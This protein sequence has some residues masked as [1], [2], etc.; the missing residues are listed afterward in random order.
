VPGRRPAAAEVDGPRLAAG[1]A[2]VHGQAREADIG[3]LRPGARLAVRGAVPGADWAGWLRRYEDAMTV[4]APMRGRGLDVLLELMELL[5]P[6]EAVV[7]DLGAGP[8]SLAGRLL[9][10]LPAARCVAVDTDPVMLELGRRVHGD[11][12]GRLRWVEADL[13][14][15]GWR[16][17]VGE[18]RVDAV[19]SSAVL[20]YLPPQDLVG[21]LREVAGLLGE[22]G[23]FL[24]ADRL[25]LPA[26]LETV[27]AALHRAGECRGE[28]AR[29]AVAQDWSGW[30]EALRDEPVLAAAFA[31]RER[32][33]LAKRGEGG[34][35]DGA[36]HE[37][38]LTAAG[39]REVATVWQDLE[40]R[41]LLAVR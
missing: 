10:R 23:V 18:P 29:R 17:A 40:E 2:L 4:H 1:A 27:V 37:R 11:A 24:G 33:A 14:E 28:A 5:V 9:A 34:A 7:L 25:P 30:W 15:G 35:V 20:H 6:A 8:G 41:V 38:A 21:V 12:G 31:R 36:S 13:L 19:V 3:G 16:S 26:H 39:F 32:T 22:G